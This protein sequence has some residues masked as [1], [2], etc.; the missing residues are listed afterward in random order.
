MSMEDFFTNGGE[1]SIHKPLVLP[2]IL[3]LLE[4]AKEMNPISSIIIPHPLPNQDIRAKG[5]HKEKEKKQ[6]RKNPPK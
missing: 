5:Y 6:R 1:A 3:I 2:I 4:M